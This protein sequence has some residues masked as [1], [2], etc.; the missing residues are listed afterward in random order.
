MNGPTPYS[1]V[2]SLCK[3][4]LRFRYLKRRGRP[5]KPQA[6]SL[7]ITH[8]CVARCMMC[9]IWRIPAE[10]PDLETGDW[11]RLLHSDLF[12]DLREIDITG[13]EPFLVKDL[14]ALFEGILA[15]RRRPLKALKSI[16]LTSNGFL[17]DRVLQFAERILPRMRSAA[18]DLVLVCAMDGIGAT[19]DR[20]RNY[21]DAWASVDRTIRGLKDLRNTF[22]NLIIGLKTTVL[23]VN[24]AQLD[25]ILRYANTH[26]LFTILSPCIITAGRYLNSECAD[27]L[28]FSPEDRKRLIEFYGSKQ[29]RW[30][31]H[32]D[33]LHRY[34]KTG[35]M[36]K[37]CSCGYNYFFVRHNGDLFLCPLI[38]RRVGNVKETTLE[39]LFHSEEADQLR[40]RTGAWPE[41]RACTEPG[42]ERYALPY[43]GFSYLSLLFRLGQKRFLQL[44]HD[45][46]LDKYL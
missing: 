45:M 34:F 36:N 40:R 10:A 38:N 17:T 18:L 1:L 33:A 35:R 37:P 14:A 41:C 20:I 39:R 30:G 22:A 6:V 3:N 24:L 8:R 27:A 28:A 32:G 46:G 42:L 44:H 21:K 7:E 13:G 31:Y 43:E 23:P 4:G 19:H 15:L 16:A 25:D 5:G 2:T 9:N 11:L 29:L 12:E 26:D